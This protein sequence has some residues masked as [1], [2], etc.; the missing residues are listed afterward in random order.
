MSHDDGERGRD[1]DDR[2]HRH[3]LFRDPPDAF[4]AAEQRQG[5]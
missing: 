5:R 2:H 4:D 3:H 1:V